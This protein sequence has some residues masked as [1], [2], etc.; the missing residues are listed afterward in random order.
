MIPQKESPSEK[1]RRLL[2]RGKSGLLRLVFSRAGLVALLLLL[3]VGLLLVMSLKFEDYLVHYYGAFSLLS[4]AMVLY[5]L[6]TDSDPSA[7]ITW[8]VLILLAPVAGS[9]L[10]MYVHTD[11]G[12]RALKARVRQLTKAA[13]PVL[14]VTE[15]DGALARSFPADA[16]IARYLQDAMGFHAYDRTAVRYFPLGDDFLPVLLA[17]LEQARSFI[18]LEY[19]IIEEGEMW[20]AVADVLERK[21]REGVEVRV[22]CD[23]TCEF[24]KLHRS[25]LR[26]LGEQGIQCRLFAPIR[27]F[28]ST[29]YNYRDHRKIAVVDG[30]VAYTGGVNL[31]DEYIN[32]AHPFGHWKDTAIRVEGEAARSFL[33][34]FLKLWQVEERGVYFG[35]YLQQPVPPVPEAPGYVIPYGDC[36]L[37]N[38]PVGEWVYTHI[39]NVARNY[40]H[41]MTP[42]LILDDK[43]ENALKFAAR[44]GVDVSIILPHIP[45]KKIPFALAK[46][47]YRTLVE[48]GVKIYEYVPGFLHAKS[49]VSDGVRGVV[50]T[51]NLDYR[52]LS[53]HFE[54]GAYLCGTPCIGDIE[55]DF[56]ETLKR[57]RRVT[58]QEAA[59]PGLYWRL[60]GTLMKPFAPLL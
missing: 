10:Y 27:P 42:Y 22:L 43:L 31:A 19:F 55:A 3:Q 49:F 14:P 36:P 47:H 51:I 7:K 39:L 33:L 35:P 9:L 8:L 50:G 12:H 2:R 38:Q 28:I 57:C 41:I 1:S 54:C 45:D 6:R 11:V 24:T 25:F 46:T 37:D 34:M 32:R 40:V 53:H 16:G 56:R 60:V 17:D 18:F 5:L 48:S 20:G 13:R 58:A 29:H 23:G 52:S 30:R 15:A 26:E 4:A 21:V 44:R 59:H